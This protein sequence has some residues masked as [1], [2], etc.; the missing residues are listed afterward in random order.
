MSF[1]PSLKAY[2]NIAASARL[3]YSFQQSW[4]FSNIS[5]C[6]SVK[7]FSKSFFVFLKNRVKRGTRLLRI[8]ADASFGAYLVHVLVLSVLARIGL[9]SLLFTAWISIPLVAA[10]AAALS[11]VLGILLRRIPV[12]GKYLS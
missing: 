3:A 11:F 1:A 9:S 2:S 4:N 7:L 12:V 5:F 6:S 8:L 10:V